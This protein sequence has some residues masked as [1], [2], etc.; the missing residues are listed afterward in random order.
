MTT[1]I[2]K[3]RSMMYTQ[4][5]R[6]AKFPDWKKEVARIVKAVEP[7]HW[8]GILHDKDNNEEGQPIEPHIHL[9][10]YFQ[11]ARSPHSVAWEINDKEGKRED[12]QIERLEFFKHPNNGYSYL[13]HQTTDAK[14]KYQY[15]ISD[16]ISNFDFP[17]KI[18]TIQKQVENAE[19]RSDGAII[20]E[21]LDL[22]YDGI[23]SLEEI[24]STL[25]GSQYAKASMRL[26]AVA[27]KRQERLVKEFIKQ[28]K[29]EKQS[30]QIVYIFGEAGLGK[31]RLAK[32]YAEN[33]AT[34]YYVSGSSRDPFQGYQNQEAV[35]ID[36]L[37]PDS[38]P[39]DDLLK[40]LDPFNF[41]VF[42]PSRYVDKALTAKTIFVTSP[43]SPKELYD[44]LHTISRI[45]RFE[46][47]ERRIETAIL[48]E[49][50]KIFHTTYNPDTQQ[51]EKEERDSF[52]NPFLP[53]Q[54]KKI[55]SEFFKQIQR[56]IKSNQQQK[57]TDEAIPH[58]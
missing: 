8:A 57:I 22:L 56:S 37:R 15:P 21:Y 58:S 16:V 49:A 50:E 29:A 35:I 12:A 42:L 51:Y 18:E 5:M 54:Q 52:S 24:E 4:Q 14:D 20:K 30:K 25:T 36:E 11:H 55:K 13:I 26:K 31:T 10:L 33:T 28:M 41:D 53:R 45:D 44:N 40:I 32:A 43:Y 27:Q 17:K 19:N 46:Q 2:K 1:K 39:Y 23:M 9:M 7:L 34:S 48:V 3:Q 6:L 47:L 38:F